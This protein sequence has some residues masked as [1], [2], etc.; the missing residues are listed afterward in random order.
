MLRRLIGADIR[1]RTEVA[2]GL[3]PCAP[4]AASSSR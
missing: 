3:G 1:L 4:T 2:A